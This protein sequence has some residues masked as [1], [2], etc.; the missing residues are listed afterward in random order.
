MYYANI[1][2]A[3]ELDA[4]YSELVR[5]ANGSEG[6]KGEARAEAVSLL[7][8]LRDMGIQL[9]PGQADFIGPEA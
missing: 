3:A 6:W 4:S 7:L 9:T 8:Q 2:L 1:K 5:E